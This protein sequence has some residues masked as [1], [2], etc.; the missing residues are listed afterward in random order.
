MHDPDALLVERVKAGDATAIEALFARH[1]DRLF[2][3]ASRMCR[4][5]HDAEDVLQ[6][7]FLSALQ[8]VARFRGDSRVTTWLYTIASHACLKK[9]RR[10]APESLDEGGG[11]GGVH[12]HDP[13]DD[14]SRR[15]DEVFR[16]KE[17]GRALADAIAAV[18]A[19]QRLVLVLRDMEGLPAPEV[20]R[21]LGISV[22]AVK[23]RLHRA[24]AEVRQRLTRHFAERAR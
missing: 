8:H 11:G 10:A 2:R 14:W 23:S 6:D 18:P 3:F 16:R 12:R 24:R 22:P 21:I 19:D 20:S 9:R 17:T 1:R 15:P 13:I 7:T 5:A 4:H